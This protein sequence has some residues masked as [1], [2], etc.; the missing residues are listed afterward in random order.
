MC[1]FH[2][3]AFIFV[4]SSYVVAHFWR[5]GESE[6]IHRAAEGW[7]AIDKVMPFI[8]AVCRIATKPSHSS[9]DSRGNEAE[10]ES[11]KSSVEENENGQ[12][13][14]SPLGTSTPNS[15]LSSSFQP[16]HL[17]KKR[18]AVQ[19]G[20]K[21][22]AILIALPEKWVPLA[23]RKGGRDTYDK[24]K[25][26]KE[27]MGKEK[28]GEVFVPLSS[29]NVFGN[30]AKS[31]PS[32]GNELHHRSLPS[33]S[34]AS[35]HGGDTAE[36]QGSLAGTV[37][38]DTFLMKRNGGGSSGGGGCAQYEERKRNQEE[39]KDFARPMGLL[40]TTSFVLPKAE[41]ASASVATFLEQPVA[42]TTIHL[43]R[44]PKPFSVA[45]RPDRKFVT[46]FQPSQE[47]YKRKPLASSWKLQEESTM[48]FSMAS[49]PS[50]LG[51]DKEG[52]QGDKKSTTSREYTCFSSD[53]G[54]ADEEE[55][56]IGYTLSFVNVDPIPL[57]S[58]VSSPCA[59]SSCSSTSPGFGTIPSF[60]NIP[61]K[62]ASPLLHNPTARSTLVKPLCTRTPPRRF[63]PALSP[64]EVD[65]LHLIRPL[66]LPLLI[67][68]LPPIRVGDAHLIVTHLNGTH[69]AYV[70]LRVTA[71]YEEYCEY[72]G[73]SLLKDFSS[74]G[75]A[76]DRDGNFVGLQHQFGKCCIALFT[77]SI[78]RQLFQSDLLGMCQSPISD[79][80]LAEL[81]SGPRIS[82]KHR[83]DMFNEP[84]HILQPMDVMDVGDNGNQLANFTDIE[85]TRSRMGVRSEPAAYRASRICSENEDTECSKHKFLSGDSA[86]PSTPFPARP[87]HHLYFSRRGG[88]PGVSNYRDTQN[89]HHLITAATRIPSFEEVHKEFFVPFSG[90][91]LLSCGRLLHRMTKTNPVVCTVGTEGTGGPSGAAAISTLIPPG[92]PAAVALSFQSLVHMLFAFWY[93]PPLMQCVLQQLTDK[94]YASFRPQMGTGGGIGAILEILDGNPED[95][96]LVEKC[97][98]A[99]A[100]LCLDV[101]NLAIFIQLNGVVSVM[102][103][104]QFYLHDNKVLQWGIRCL[105]CATNSQK[106]TQSHD[107]VDTFLR[108]DGLEVVTYALNRHG[109]MNRHLASW[110]A[111]LLDHLLDVD[112]PP[113]G[114]L[115]WMLQKGLPIMVMTFLMEHYDER[116]ILSGILP[117]LAHV[118]IQLKQFHDES[119]LL[120]TP[121]RARIERTGAAK[122]GKEA[123]SPLLVPPPQRS[124]SA[125]LTDRAG[126]TLPLPPP[127]Q[128]VDKREEEEEVEEKET[129]A[130]APAQLSERRPTRKAGHTMGERGAMEERSPVMGCEENSTKNSLARFSFKNFSTGWEQ[131]QERDKAFPLQ[132]E[133]LEGSEEKEE[134]V[135]DDDSTAVHPANN[136][137][138]KNT[139]LCH[140]FCGMPC[141]FSDF[142]FCSIQ[143]ETF[144]RILQEICQMESAGSRLLSAPELL[145]HVVRILKVRLSFGLPVSST[146]TTVVEEVLGRVK[147]HLPTEVELIEGLEKV[148]DLQYRLLP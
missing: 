134:V 59:I 76:F 26:S 11:H 34:L 95:H 85:L 92:I 68:Q 14:A 133:D 119:S 21:G 39:E 54:D 91:S 13:I 84:F 69:R 86:N 98:G 128:V 123:G 62:P 64:L 127:R 32:R 143:D 117:Y 122:E 94:R 65:G 43:K 89:T 2:A 16:V 18:S 42:G 31:F 113:Y 35:P 109:P 87:P 146:F 38:R 120:K 79:L 20:G 48:T 101:G 70:P 66:P 126:D 107:A 55:E 144:L 63:P 116:I 12:T 108:Y 49:V 132:G 78:V 82:N 6:M 15:S 105:M 73:D 141:I 136:R 60:E 145:H 22:S 90:V 23:C 111:T 37:G 46:S 137:K 29:P 102:E 129:P 118:I 56:E 114:Y 96:E 103:V 25:R 115:A 30:E 19:Q 121:D 51:G 131:R 130:T 100:L 112:D 33:S 125:S 104:L 57:L 139:S 45:L 75:A 110:I 77:S 97:L 41:V 7:E 71:V 36:R 61:M 99:L 27:I 40:L 93:N 17:K 1:V 50:L 138:G 83:A 9:L 47:P 135:S 3:R 53:E 44:E 80:P 142:L 74:G 106:A 72:E 124:E 58:P 148:L 28:C 24:E 147:K 8:H 10:R 4:L 81:R 140:P 52:S 67:S 88:P 5:K